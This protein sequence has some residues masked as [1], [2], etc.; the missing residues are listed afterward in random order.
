[1][2]PQD[3]LIVWLRGDRAGLGPFS[4][5]LVDQYWR[6]EQDPSVLIGYGRQT[7]D[8]LENR[9]EGYGH[10]ARGTDDQLRFTVYDLTGQ[11]PVPVGT[12]A[13]LIDHHVR[14]GEFVIQLGAG[15]RGRGL[16]TEA[17]RLTL[18]YAF[19]VSALACVHLAVLTPNTGAIAAYERAGFRRI[20]ERRDSGFWLGRRVSETLMDAVPEDF[21][22][23]SVV[24]GFVEGGR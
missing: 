2:S 13:V 9:R 17:T 11:D 22:G 19:H 3:D 20:G 21:P 4:A 1:M 5:D 12:T 7:P 15:H 10:Q 6:W 23:P 16:G 8:S 18:D 24:R 14:T